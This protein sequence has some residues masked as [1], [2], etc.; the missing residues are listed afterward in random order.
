MVYLHIYV[1]IRMVKCQFG[2]KIDYE[3][4]QFEYSIQ[5]FTVS[6]TIRMDVA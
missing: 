3:I 5:Y 1:N 2:T 4:A 6:I